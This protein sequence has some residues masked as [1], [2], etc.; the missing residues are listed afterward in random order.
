MH[1]AHLHNVTSSSLLTGILFVVVVVAWGFGLTAI[2]LADRQQR[3]YYGLLREHD[4][5]LFRLTHSLS[6]YGRHSPPLSSLEY[7]NVVHDT[8]K[9]YGRSSYSIH[10]DM[11]VFLPHR[12][13]HIAADP[14][15]INIPARYWQ[16]GY[17]TVRGSA[18]PVPI[19]TSPVF[20][21]D[22]DRYGIHSITL[23][24]GRRLDYVDAALSLFIQAFG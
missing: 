13:Q 1:Q 22:E 17:F 18:G 3:L 24:I 5:L 12:V 8:P 23:T 10:I 15:P 19:L 7:A 14:R 6:H 21:P 11:S 2:L 20:L 9:Q 4:A 16:G